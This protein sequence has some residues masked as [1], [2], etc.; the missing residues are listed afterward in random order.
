[1][2]SPP[3]AAATQERAARCFAIR[4]RYYFIGFLLHLLFKEEM[5]AFY[6]FTLKEDAAIISSLF[7]ARDIS[8]MMPL[9]HA[10]FAAFHVFHEIL[11]MR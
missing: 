8:Y 10:S 9:R 1:M 2:F 5:P 11:Q 7:E 4:E 3:Y 6:A